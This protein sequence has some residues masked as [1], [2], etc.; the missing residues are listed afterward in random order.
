MN[1]ALKFLIFS[2]IILQIR[3]IHDGQLA[4]V[5][6]FPH[7]ALVQGSKYFCSGAIVTDRHVIL[8][9]HCLLDTDDVTVHVGK[10][11]ADSSSGQAI[12]SDTYWMHE[13]FE[14]PA[15]NDDIG[16]IRLPEA[17]E[18]N[19][20][21]RKIGISIE[22]NVD[23]DRDDKDVVLAGWGYTEEA[24]EEADSLRYAEMS[25]I[26]I[27]KCLKYKKNYIEELTEDHICLKKERGMPCE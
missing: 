26:P 13:N 10:L 6:Q 7:V 24:N 20:M 4:K 21:V 11:S 16:I 5:R 9:A 12:V 3:A 18:F 17:L 27:K 14:M 15:A 23:L 22:R 25:L 8:A 2:C 19:K 1:F